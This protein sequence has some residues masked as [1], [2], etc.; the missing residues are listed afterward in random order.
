MQKPK[1]LVL[2]FSDIANDARVKKQVLLFAEQYDV[3]TC[4][5]GAAV[6]PEVE[7]LQLPASTSVAWSYLN[8]VLLRARLYRLD[9][10]LQPNVR[11]ARRALRGKSFDVVIANDID[12]LAFAVKRFGGARVHSDLH[13]FFPG[14][15]DNNSTW[16]RVRKPQLEWTLRTFGSQAGSVTTVSETIAERYQAEYGLACDVVRNAAPY[17]SFSAGAVAAPI[18]MVHSGGAF[19]E[20]RIDVMMR[21]AALTKTDLIFDLYLTQ[22]DSPHGKELRA[23][24]GELG[25]RV[26]VHPPVPQGELVALLNSY[27][28]GIHVLPATNTNNSLALPNKFFDYVQARLGMVIGPTADMVKLLERYELGRVA[29]GFDRDT[30]VAALDT[31][32][33]HEVATWKANAAAAAQECSAEAQQHVWEHA[34][35]SRLRGSAA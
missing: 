8:G 5:F 29:D 19:A 9:A 33:P 34:V 4:G 3:V 10:W 30:I 22:P 24:A 35:A 7:H 27:D 13:E 2:S 21:A 23:L 20:R 26:T 6:L 16:V 12:T 31:L 15:H 14:L 17:R 28:V 18:R 1:L 32:T 11:A 25:E